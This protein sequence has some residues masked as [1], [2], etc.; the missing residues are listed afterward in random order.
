MQGDVS[1]E[2]F[3]EVHP[4]A[5][6]VVRLVPPDALRA[7][8]PLCAALDSAWFRASHLRR[9]AR[10]AADSAMRARR[11]RRDYWR[12][13]ADSLARGVPD[14]SAR[15]SNAEAAVLGFFDALPGYPTGSTGHYA[16]GGMRPGPYLLYAA[17]KLRTFWL[18]P[19]V[20]P[21]GGRTLDLD[22]R[23]AS[24]GKAGA[25]R[26]IAQAA[27]TFDAELREAGDDD[28]LVRAEPPAL[29]DRAAAGEAFRRN[30]PRLL[31][32]AGVTGSAQISFRVL[33][34]GTVDPYSIEIDR[35]SDA[36]FGD[37]A[38]LA[39]ETL[40]FRPA[41]VEGRSV[42]AWVTLPVTFSLEP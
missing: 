40:R 27:C 30:Y 38:A 6:A 41:Q 19:V 37:A 42:A 26:S 2:Y 20:V 29:L 12:A 36:A 33:A 1:L 18:V 7:A 5:D 13:V 11:D 34:D 15:A 22:S 4:V 23:N 14:A 8:A 24:E 28:A 31:R 10:V 9:D 35:A 39:A 17:L 21:A 3:G 25:W 16:V 32:D